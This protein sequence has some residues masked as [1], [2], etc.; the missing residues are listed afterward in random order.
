M[1]AGFNEKRMRELLQELL[2]GKGKISDDIA[3]AFRVISKIYCGQLT[4][5]ARQ[6]QIEEIAMR[7]GGRQNLPD[8]LKIGP[9]R[10]Y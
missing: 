5:E 6:V 7:Y 3:Q 10:P 4:E 9:I 8:T 1:E 2:G